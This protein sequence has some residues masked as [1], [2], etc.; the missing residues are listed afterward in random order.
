MTSHLDSHT[1]S[2][3]KPDMLSGV[4][5]GNGIPHD[6]HNIHGIAHAGTNRKDDIF[7]Q[8]RVYI[9]EAHTALDIFRFVVF[10]W[11]KMFSD[12]GFFPVPNFFSSKICIGP[13]KILDPKPF[14]GFGTQQALCW[15]ALVMW[16]G[17]N[18]I[19][20]ILSSIESQ[21]EKFFVVIVVVVVFVV[22][23]VIIVGHKNLILMFGQNWVNNK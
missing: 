15:F 13:K 2:D 22:V 21:P 19:L 1:T 18:E 23:V 7:M 4:Q 12:Q 17:N 3:V 20:T 10:F 6:T 11:V 14:F 5:T 16:L 8:R 9:D